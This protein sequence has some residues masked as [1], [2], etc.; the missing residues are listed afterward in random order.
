MKTDAP[1]D[2]KKL[3]RALAG[4]VFEHC[5]DDDYEVFSFGAS[6]NAYAMRELL[7]VGVLR[8]DDDDIDSLKMVSAKWTKNEYTPNHWVN[9]GDSE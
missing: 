6:C 1:I 8:Q 9:D 2:T 5:S 4:M 3:I 7:A